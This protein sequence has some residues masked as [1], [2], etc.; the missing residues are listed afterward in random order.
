VGTAGSSRNRAPTKGLPFQAIR[1]DRYSAKKARHS[2]RGPASGRV[3][4]RLNQRRPAERL[5][6]TQSRCNAMQYLC[7]IVQVEQR[8]A[9][10]TPLVCDAALGAWLQ[11]SLT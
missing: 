3:H 9:N 5:F 2:D 4:V 10:A 6:R 11:L 1:L 7:A 8:L